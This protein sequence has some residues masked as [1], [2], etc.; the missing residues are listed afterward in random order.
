MA[1]STV[2]SDTCLVK[3]FGKVFLVKVYGNIFVTINGKSF[4][5]DN[6]LPK[7]IFRIHSQGF[8]R[9]FKLSIFHFHFFFRINCQ[10][11]LEYL[12]VNL[13]F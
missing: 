3:V 7:Y 8:S 4:R 2:S 13:V 1:L 9:N 11:Y 6:Q 5:L 12:F 10:I